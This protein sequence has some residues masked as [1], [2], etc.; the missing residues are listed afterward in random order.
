MASKDLDKIIPR[1][2]WRTFAASLDA[3]ER[4]I[5]PLAD[6]APRDSSEIYVLSLHGPQNAKLR[7]DLIDIKR[8][9]QVDD[10]GLE[11]WE[12]VFKARFPLSRSDI[13]AAFSEWHLLLPALSLDSY[14]IEEFFNS[15]IAAQPALRVARV[16]KSRRGFVFQG[17]IAS[18]YD[19]R[20]TCIPCRASRSSTKIAA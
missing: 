9:Q 17:C 20:S 16:D 15:L 10:D 7:D 19:C 8:L 3:L 11:L 18:L 1:W 4:A 14:T 6:V 2:E 13:A 5:G 12:P